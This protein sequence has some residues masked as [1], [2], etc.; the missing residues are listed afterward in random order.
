MKGSCLMDTNTPGADAPSEIADLAERTALEDLFPGYIME[1]DA[2]KGKKLKVE[3][4]PLGITHL[5]QFN[6]QLE[7]IIP[8]IASQ[9]DLSKLK[10]HGEEA[11]ADIMPILAPMILT[12]LLDLVNACTKGV[13]LL[14]SYVPHWIL[15]QIIERWLLESFGDAKK[16]KPWVSAVETLMAK[17]TGTKL[18]I[19][20]TLSKHLSHLGTASDPSSS[21]SSPASPTPDGP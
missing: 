20:D 21:T 4:F 3:V 11:I 13:D 18:G 17:M 5:R 16:L 2:A 1:F 9:V 15:P 6:R 12:D 10:E 7:A 14:N 19:W 8:K